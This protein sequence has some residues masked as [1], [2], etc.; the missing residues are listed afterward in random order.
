MTQGDSGSNFPP[1][2]IAWV[3]FHFVLEHQCHCQCALKFQLF[4]IFYLF[5]SGLPVGQHINLSAS[6]NGEPCIRSYTPVSSDEDLGYMDLVVKV[7]FALIK[8]SN[9]FKSVSS[10]IFN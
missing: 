10:Q 9:P 5:S 7:C 4:H 6:I 3:W 2:L 1:K 8:L